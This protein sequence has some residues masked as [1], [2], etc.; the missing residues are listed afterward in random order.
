MTLFCWG[1]Y[2]EL[3]Y[4]LKLNAS[5]RRITGQIKLMVYLLTVDSGVSDLSPIN[6]RFDTYLRQCK[7]T[8][9]V[10]SYS[11]LQ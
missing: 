3:P 7:Q 4:I 9:V 6:D 11:A 2:F 5:R 10:L 1:F 8:W